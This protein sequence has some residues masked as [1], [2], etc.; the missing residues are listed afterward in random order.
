[1]P[2]RVV[3]VSNFV[4]LHWQGR[5][6]NPQSLTSGVHSRSVLKGRT[7]QQRAASSPRGL[8]FFCSPPCSDSARLAGST[9]PRAEGEKQVQLCPWSSHP[10]PVTVGCRECWLPAQ[11]H[12]V[13]DEPRAV[14]AYRCLAS[15]RGLEKWGRTRCQMGENCQPESPCSPSHVLDQPSV[16]L[17][18][19]FI[20]HP[21]HPQATLHS[22]LSQHRT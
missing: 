9:S 2:K 4:R 16:F 20:I 15:I 6:G 12:L 5:K 10:V 3:G 18:R 11:P 1:M 14:M 8:A 21:P 22:R 7:K 13:T 19:C 17:F